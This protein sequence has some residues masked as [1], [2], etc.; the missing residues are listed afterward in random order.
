[1]WALLESSQ[2][3]LGK[4]STNADHMM[5][6]IFRTASLPRFFSDYANYPELPK[7][8]ARK[9]SAMVAA[10]AG[11]MVLSRVV[12]QSVDDDSPESFLGG[13]VVAYGIAFNL[14]GLIMTSMWSRDMQKALVKDEER[15]EKANARFVDDMVFFAGSEV[16]LVYKHI[17]T[18]LRYFELP[19]VNSAEALT[20]LFY[21]PMVCVL[22]G[23]GFHSYSY[24]EN[25]THPEHW[26]YFLGFGLSNLFGLF[27]AKKVLEGY[28]DR[29]DVGFAFIL[30]KFLSNIYFIHQAHHSDLKSMQ[31]CNQ[32]D[33][34]LFFAPRDAEKYL[35][36]G[37]RQGA[38]RL[39]LG[40]LLEPASPSSEQGKRDEAANRP[41]SSIQP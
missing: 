21:Y 10:C 15:V 28:L 18:L 32:I 37:L 12:G 27:L 33:M 20:N 34:D 35:T 14:A 2:V 26:D 19:L 36:P 13:L 9:T 16:Q 38:E 24:D 40:H 17:P 4:F 31:N 7:S 3:A 23:M 29:G 5:R 8:F 39:G 11:G 25:A 22:T 41:V 6:G 30:I 1:M